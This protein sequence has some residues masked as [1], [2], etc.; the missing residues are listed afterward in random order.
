M[1]SLTGIIQNKIDTMNQKSIYLIL[2]LSMAVAVF[3]GCKKNDEDPGADIQPGVGLKYVKIGDEAQRAFDAYGQTPTTYIES[4]G[5]FI[6]LITY[7]STGIL[8]VLEPT[9]SASFDSK[10]AIHSFS[11]SAPYSG[12]TD[13][14]IGIGST[15]TEVRD[16]Y[17]QPNLSDATTDSYLVLGI[18]FTYDATSKVEGILVSK[19]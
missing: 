12:K 13:L 16:A 15:K 6:H 19:F 10:T 1:Q 7:Q 17:G 8:V 14:N 3:S 11:L 18:V 5:Q 2:C 4:N 9:N